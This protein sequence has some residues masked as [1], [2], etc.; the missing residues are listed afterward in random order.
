MRWLGALIVSLL[1]CVFCNDVAFAQD[2]ADEAELHFRLANKRYETQDYEGALEHYLASNRLS[3]NKNVVYN[4]ARTYEQLKQPAD[5]Y[6]W[7]VISLEGSTDAGFVRRAQDA[8]TRIR[9][10]VGLLRVETQPPGATLYLDRKDLGARGASPRLLALVPGQYVVL[11]E[12]AGYELGKSEPV[13][14]RAGGESTLTVKLVPVLGK[15]HVDVPQ[16]AEGA[17]VRIDKEDGPVACHAPCDLDAPVGRRTLYVSK[18]GFQTGDVLVDVPQSATVTARARMVAQYGTLLANADLRD[19]LVLVDGKASGFTPA[20]LTVPVGAHV[21]RITSAGFVP[22]EESIVVHNGEQVKVDAEM[23]VSDEVAA[24]SRTTESTADAPA[25]VTIITK[26]ELRAMGYPTI[27]EAVRGVR[28]VFLSDDRAYEAVGFRGFARPGDYGNRVLVTLDGQPTNDDYLGSSYVGYDARVDLDDVER[29]EVIRGPGS[30]LYGTGAF[31]GVINLVTRSRQQRTH[32][33]LGAGASGDGVGR[34]RATG[35]VRLGEDMGAWNS[36]SIARGT[37][38]DFFFPEFASDPA[39]GG[40]ARGIDGFDA[41]TLGGRAFW[42]ALSVQWFFNQRRKQLPTAAYGAIFGDPRQFVKDTRAFIEAK[43]E[44]KIGNNIE[45]LVRAHANLYDFD[46]GT[47]YAPDP[48]AMPP[49]PAR[50][51]RTAFKGRWLG[52][53]VRLAFMQAGKFRIAAGVDAAFHATTHQSNSDSAQGVYASRDDPYTQLAPYIVG[54]VTPV[55]ELKIHAGARLDWFSNLNKFDTVAAFS[56]RLG[57]ILRPYKRGNVKI[58]AGKAFRAPSVYELFGSGGGQLQ[59]P[60]LQPEQIYS[61]E[62]EWSHRFTDT[63]TGALAG[64]AN[65]VSGLI[66]LS[67]DPMNPMQ[68]LYLNTT[69][70]IV[71]GGEAELRREWK[72]G[73]MFG[74][75]ASVQKAA[76]LDAPDLRQVPNSPIALGSVKG[77]APIIGRNLVIMTRVAAS[78]PRPDGNSYAGRNG[79]VDPPQQTTETGVIWDLVLSGEFEKLA[80]RYALGFYNI[81]D[82]RHDAVP[83]RDFAPLRTIAQR[84]RTVLATLEVSF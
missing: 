82:W 16:G 6:R 68:N 26:Q 5:A 57:A 71:G 69:N 27:A 29:I 61:G 76:Y 42:K 25:S 21:V 39:T 31:F 23:I 75:T 51:D 14:L 41:G 47:P 28:G 9:P 70:V 52:A 30:V 58:L 77:A 49:L 83:S 7:Y 17:E 67:P 55:K 11:A 78:G 38:R 10:L 1:I 81:A 48:A 46:D 64:Y 37:G 20:V 53:E 19:G 84:G 45:L 32:A 13:S 18:P 15:V 40:N 43:F 72:H 79:I 65:Y 54:D 8:I 50:L 33:E 12:L 59:N 56:P 35:F 24:A 63:I 44:P 34:A 73:F 36:V 2:T 60:N 4:I 66:E 74:V 80:A 3:P 22:Y 62:V